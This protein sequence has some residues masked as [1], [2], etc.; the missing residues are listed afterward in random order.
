M[1]E[2][3]DGGVEK[4][5]IFPPFAIPQLAGDR[6]MGRMSSEAGRG[7]ERETEGPTSTIL[8]YRKKMWDEPEEYL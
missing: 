1:P 7:G 2:G 4:Q 8:L 5:L 6:K 3:T